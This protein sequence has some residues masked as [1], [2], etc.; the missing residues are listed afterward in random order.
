MQ[1]V[2]SKTGAAAAS[3]SG[4]AGHSARSEGTSRGLPEAAPHAMVVVDATG[5]IWLT[6]V[7]L[8][9]RRASG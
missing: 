1:D 7:T 4:G 2:E 6:T 5:K 3:A 9:Q 8:P